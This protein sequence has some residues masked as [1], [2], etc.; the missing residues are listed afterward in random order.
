MKDWYLG[1]RFEYKI[2]FWSLVSLVAITICLIPLWFFS[3]MEVPQGILLGGSVGVIT[4]LLLGLFNNPKKQKQSLV[5]T[6]IIMIVRFLL[7]AGILFLVGWLY[8][9]KDMKAFNIFAV[10]G[11][12]TLT[13]IVNIVLVRMEKVSGNIQ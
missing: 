10:V 6:T 2:A 12:Y 13:I 1:L 3:L 9:V 11:G 7:I 5:I 4:Y 8:Y